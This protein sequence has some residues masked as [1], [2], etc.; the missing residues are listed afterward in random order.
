MAHD[1]TTQNQ[2]RK[3]EKQ[4]A[5]PDPLQHPST[6]ALPSRA[7]LQEAHPHPENLHGDSSM[8]IVASPNGIRLMPPSI[9]ESFEGNE[10]ETVLDDSPNAPTGPHSF[11]G[12]LNHPYEHSGETEHDSQPQ[13][14]IESSHRFVGGK[15]VD[16][17]QAG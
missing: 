16:V 5:G 2:P 12:T 6:A 8:V 7:L 1:P 13:D 14:T 4:E 15:L 11:S 17:Q 10:N 9:L 3:E